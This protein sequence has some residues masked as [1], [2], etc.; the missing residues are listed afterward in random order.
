MNE[1]ATAA[2]R[3]GHSLLRPHIPRMSPSYAPVEPPILLRDGF[4]NPDMVYQVQHTAFTANV[5]FFDEFNVSLLNRL[6]YIS[7][8]KKLTGG[9]GLFNPSNILCMYLLLQVNMVDEIT[10][11]LL[12]TPVETLDQFITGEITNHLFED[13]RVPHSGI[14]LAA[15]NIQR[16]KNVQLLVFSSFTITA[17]R[18]Q[19][20]NFYSRS[21]KVFTQISNTVVSANFRALVLS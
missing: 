20:T 7:K 1:F 14:D 11:G 12:T 15:L 8:Y 13:R 17:I 9:S 5:R 4:F 18:R 6:K 16:G 21:T 10:R 19:S 3:I 2:F